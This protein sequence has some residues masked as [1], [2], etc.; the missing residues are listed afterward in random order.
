MNRYALVDKRGKN[1]G[2]CSAKHFAAAEKAFVKQR[3]GRAIPEGWAI[4]T[5][6]GSVVTSKRTKSS[7]S[8]EACGIAEVMQEIKALRAGVAADVAAVR[9]DMDAVIEER[10]ALVA[11]LGIVNTQLKRAQDAV[12]A[13]SEQDQTRRFLATQIADIRALVRSWKAQEAT[14]VATILYAL[15]RILERKD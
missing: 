7:P 4:E 13:L 11:E 9:R 15:G 3:N 1:R 8:Q 5:R 6:K 14:T 2:T 12:I 10:D